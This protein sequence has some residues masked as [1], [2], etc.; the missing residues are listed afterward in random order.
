MPRPRWETSREKVRWWRAGNILAQ[1]VE[2]EEYLR[3]SQT[4]ENISDSGERSGRE[5]GSRVW[6]AVET[7]QVADRLLQLVSAR[8]TQLWFLVLSETN[9]C[10]FL[11]AMKH[12]FIYLFLCATTNLT[13]RRSVYLYSRGHHWSLHPMRYR[14]RLQWCECQNT[15]T[16]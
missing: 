1:T 11:S 4:P 13:K 8:K 2:N 14:C 12:N 6:R 15:E 5:R 9:H 10:L 7:V 3:I 16:K